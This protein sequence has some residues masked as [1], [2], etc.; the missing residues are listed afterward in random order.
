VSGAFAKERLARMHR[1]MAGYVERGEL[2][3]MVTLLCRRDEVHADAIGT[4][5]VGGREPMRRDTIFRITSMTKPITA[6]AA[7]I[8]VEECRL[9]LDDPVDRWLPELANRKVLRRPDGPLDD[10]VPARRAITLRDLLTFRLGLG[11]IAHSDPW[12]IQLAE[13]ALGT[14]GFSPPNVACPH[15]PDEWMRRIGTLP[16]QHQPGEV[17]QYGLGSYVLGVLIA[18]AAGQPFE[19]FLRERLFEP[20]GMKDTGFTVPAAKVGRLAASYRV[21]PA[22]GA[23]APYDDPA[24]SAWSRPPAFPDGGAGLVSTCDDF[25]AFGRMLL[26]KGRHGRERILSRAAVETMTTDQLTDA[27]RADGDCALFLEG[28][29]WGFGV[30]IDLR[31]RDLA[32][33]PGRFGWDGGYGTSWATDPREELVAIHMTQRAG[34]PGASGLYADFWTSA[35]QTLED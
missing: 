29:G 1:V 25:L 19:T 31:R 22:T 20:L 6:A 17:W 28:R 32:S 26:E 14:V 4:L 21:D 30:A 2:P 16:L 33:V 27:Q 3:G 24:D 23:L 12:P 34:F 18:R 9:R 35:Y 13:R 8:L 10:T 15:D 11:M 7:L 5:S